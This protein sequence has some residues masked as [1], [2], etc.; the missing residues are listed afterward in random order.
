M[1][2][3]KRYQDVGNT[4]RKVKNTADLYE[5]TQNRLNKANEGT[6][7]YTGDYPGP[8]TPQQVKAEM[9]RDDEYQMS[10]DYG[11]VLKKGGTTGFDPMNMKTTNFK[12]Y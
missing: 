11:M 8:V 6:F 4:V 2:S 10:K 3:P 1:L 12:K 9:A 5:R 7:S